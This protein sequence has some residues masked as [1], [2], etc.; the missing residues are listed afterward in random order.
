MERVF[1]IFLGLD[2]ARSGN[3]RKASATTSKIFSRKFVGTIDK[4]RWFSRIKE[5]RKEKR[6]VT[7]LQLSRLKQI[8]EPKPNLLGKSR[9]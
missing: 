7:K 2:I 9:V 4:L 3:N 5:T 8:S 1:F 6:C